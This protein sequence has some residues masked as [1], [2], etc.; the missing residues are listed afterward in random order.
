M[1]EGN[2]PTATLKTNPHSLDK[3]ATEFASY[4]AWREGKLVRA[5]DQSLPLAPQAECAHARFRQ[6]V[7]DPDFPCIGAK[8][9]INGNCYR[10]GFYPEMNSARSSAALAHDLWFYAAERPAF[11]S[12]YATFIACFGAPAVANEKSWENLLWAQLQNLHELDRSPWDATVSNDPENPEF[13]FSFAG[14][15]FFVVG[16]NP[17][18]SRTARRFPYPTLVFNAHAQFERLRAQ[19]KFE[20]M[21]QTVRARD[22]KLQGSINPNLSDYGEQSEARQYSGRAVEKNWRCPFRALFGKDKEI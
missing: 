18:S 21:R 20:R 14:T 5:L 19:N 15:A 13:S 8:A 4:A 16:L 1:Y 11:N 2:N 3:H 10:F 6:F 22:T 7:A 12:D 17:S 9:A